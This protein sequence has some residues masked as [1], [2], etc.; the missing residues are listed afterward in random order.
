[1]RNKKIIINSLLIFALFLILFSS[2]LLLAGDSRP[3]IESITNIEIL[4]V[5]EDVGPGNFTDI[6]NPD[7]RPVYGVNTNLFRTPEN[8]SD[9]VFRKYIK[10]LSTSVLRF[11]GGL[12]DFYNHENGLIEFNNRRI[13]SWMKT[14]KLAKTEINTAIDLVQQEVGAVLYVINIHDSL[15]KIERLVKKLK[16]SAMHIVG[17]EIGNENYTLSLAEEIGGATKYLQRVH[18]IVAKIKQIDPTIPVS[19]N[20][21]PVWLPGQ[22]NHIHQKHWRNWNEI[23]R[24]DGLENIDAVVVHYYPFVKKLGFD[25]A[26]EVSKS[27]FELMIKEIREKYPSKQIWVTEWNLGPP[28]SSPYFSSL[29]HAFFCMDMVLAILRNSV[30]LNCYHVLTGLGWELIGPDRAVLKYSSGS[31]VK[32]LRRVPYF[33]LKIFNSAYQ[34]AT[35]FYY[36]NINGIEFLVF[37]KEGKIDL[38][39]WSKE[40][41]NYRIDLGEDYSDYDFVEGEALKHEDTDTTN[42]NISRAMLNKSRSPWIENCNIQSARDPYINLPGIYRFQYSE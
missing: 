11:P 3:K 7:S 30:E 31:K 1:M 26:I 34:Q 29:K 32:T 37:K 35:S 38:L 23:L 28:V 42:G 17:F 15:D 27:K 24:L 41:V 19:V 20:L 13:L 10:E 14:G 12:G 6:S 4:D 25:N 39:V 5:L 8:L 33:A 9:Q 16:K 40:K 18:A 21:A 36:N 2:I 22:E